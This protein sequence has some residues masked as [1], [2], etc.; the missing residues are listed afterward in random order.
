MGE[1]KAGIQ[2]ACGAAIQPAMSLESQNLGNFELQ[3]LLCFFAP[4]T[5]TPLANNTRN[6][7]QG[8]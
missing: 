8:K 4:S 7:G 5:T 2:A 6:L 1:C 3:V